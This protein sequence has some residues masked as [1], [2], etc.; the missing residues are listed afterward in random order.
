MTKRKPIPED[1]I[2]LREELFKKIFDSSPLGIA[3][4]TKELIFFSVNSAWESMTGYSEKELIRLTVRDITHPEHISGDMENIRML[5]EGKIPV[6]RTEKRY[7]RKN[8]SILWGSLTVSVLRSISGSVEYLVAQIEDITERKEAEIAIKKSEQQFRET[9]ELLDEGYYHCTLEGTL[10]E[11]N[12]AFNRILGIELS[13]NMRGVMMPEFWQVPQKRE[14]YLRELRSNGFVRNMIIDAKTIDGKPITVLASAHLIRD[15]V[16]GQTIE[17][18]FTDISDLR[19]TENALREER[20]FSHLLLD[21]SPA[22]YVAIDSNGRTLMMNRAL[23]DALE[24]TEDEV[25]GKDYLTSF[26]PQEDRE[27]LQPVF[28]KNRSGTTTVNVNRI[29][30][31]SGKIFIVEWHGKPVKQKQGEKEGFFVGVGIDITGRHRAETALRESEARLRSFIETTQDAITIIDEDGQ[32]IEWNAGSERLSGIS[33][34]DALGKFIWDVNFHLIPPERQTET[35]YAELKESMKKALATGIPVFR[36]PTV[37]EAAKEDGTRFF[38]RHTIFPI[39]TARGYRFGSVVQDITREKLAEEA[40]RETTRK[41]REAQEMAHMG[42][43]SWD[44]KTG[45][46]EWS[47]EVFRIFGLDPRTF[48]PTIDSVLAR[49]PWP[50]DHERDKELIRRAIDSHE[51]GTYE[52]RFLR[53]DNSTG[54]YYSTFQGQYDNAGNLVSIIGTVLDITERRKADEAFR[55]SEVRFRTLVSQMPV[56]IVMTKRTDKGEDVI[57]LNEKFTEITGY[58]IDDIPSFAAWAPLAYPDPDY[59]RIITAMVPDIFSEAANNLT[60]N[61][62]VTRVTCNDG[63]VKDVEFRYTSL[64]SFGFWTMADITERLRAEEQRDILI[65]ELEGKNAELE[66]FTYTVSHD[67]KSPLITIRGFAGLLERDSETGNFDILKRDI[68]RINNAAETMQAL[69]NDILELSRVGRVINPPSK[70]SFETIAWEA[71]DLLEGPVTERGVK[72]DIASG[73]P[74]VQVDHVRIREVLVNLIENAIKFTG[75]RTDPKI[76]IGVDTGGP[77]P[78]FYVR[79]N[80]I[81]IDPRYLNRIFNLFEKLEPMIPGTG[82]GLPIVKRIIEMHGGKIWAESEGVGKGT[83]FKFT[84][85]V[86]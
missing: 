55:E 32:V 72:I 81:G 86:S 10:I 52:Q 5:M 63:T 61:P 66:R 73:L 46:V 42:F 9:L 77:E 65:R 36:E 2:P 67:L 37:F 71:V 76:W 44:V 23:L 13:K 3:L 39:K 80:G 31:K 68:G 30:S 15:E 19:N 83:T 38:S 8:G 28:E 69:L 26:V 47:D 57:Y 79:D 24:Y 20:E 62:R 49:S 7:I 78:V 40:L 18:T 16:R 33:R 50:E 64:K 21:A 75:P 85:P 60:S 34:A 6:Y 12:L 4:V 22:F 35:R 54:Y 59:R 29:I 70:V 84:L 27:S 74:E 11:H 58:T 1:A 41:L 43:W 51:P 14:E 48:K 45:D 25:K 53:P 82:I 17:G 56:G